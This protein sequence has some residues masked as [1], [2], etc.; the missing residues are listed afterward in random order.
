MTT[1]L[2]VT[3][4][5]NELLDY[6]QSCETSPSYEE[7]MIA[8]RLKSKSGVHRLIN[9]LEERGFIRRIKNRARTIEL[10]ERPPVQAVEIAHVPASLRSRSTAD[11]I[12]ELRSRGFVVSIPLKDA[13]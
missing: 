13:A 9:G 3:Q 8:L 5:Q 12:V 2:G 1:R 7:M 10:V 6:I 4:K 11:L